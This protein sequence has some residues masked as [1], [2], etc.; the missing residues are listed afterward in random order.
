MLAVAECFDTD[1]SD[2]LDA[3]EFGD[4]LS[5][6]SIH[7][8]ARGLRELFDEID[9]CGS[10]HFSS[11]LC[12]LCSLFCSTLPHFPAWSTGPNREIFSWVSGKR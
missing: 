7:L 12:S 5:M 8:E 2:E 3:D 1:N 9:T 4:A 10:A 11:F 6:L